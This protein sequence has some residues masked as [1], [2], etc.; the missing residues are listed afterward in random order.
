MTDRLFA[1]YDRRDKLK[2][3][4]NKDEEISFRDKLQSLKDLEDVT[5]ECE[6]RRELAPPATA[7]NH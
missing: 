3:A 2:K 6:K 4:K 1:S 5:K 7:V